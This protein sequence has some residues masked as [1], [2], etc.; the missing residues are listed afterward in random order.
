LSD[1][2]IT[3]EPVGPTV[4][5]DAAA[6]AASVTSAGDGANVP[7]GDVTTISLPVLMRV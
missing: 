4:P 6:A 2:E 5:Q 3:G 1:E 7:A